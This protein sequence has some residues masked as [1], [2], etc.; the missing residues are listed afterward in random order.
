M[1]NDLRRCPPWSAIGVTKQVR[2]GQVESERLTEELEGE[3]R[4]LRAFEDRVREK[5]AEVEREQAT[6]EGRSELSS[7]VNFYIR[8]T[9]KGT[10][11]ISQG[12][13]EPRRHYVR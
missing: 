13:S 10:V 5:K 11:V 4:D 8:N 3:R 2:Q 7:T 6:L 1:P 12:C 9:S